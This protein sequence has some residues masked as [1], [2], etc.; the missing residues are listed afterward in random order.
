MV[1]DT[2][3]TTRSLEQ[4]KLDLGLETLALLEDPKTVEIM[5]NHK[6]QSST[7][8]RKYPTR[9]SYERLRGN[10]YDVKQYSKQIATEYNDE[11]KQNELDYV[12]KSKQYEAKSQLLTEEFNN[13]K[14]ASTEE[15]AYLQSKGVEATKGIYMKVVKNKHYTCIPFFNIEGKI[16][17][18]QYI[19]EYGNKRFETGG[20]KTGSFHVINGFD[21][22]NTST[23]GIIIAEGYATANTVNEA[24]NGKYSVIAAGD[25]GNLENVAKAIRSKYPNKDIIIAADNDHIRE[26]NV[27][28][29]HATQAAKNVGAMLVYPSFS[30]GVKASDFNDL[31]KISGIEVVRSSIR[32]QLSTQISNAKKLQQ[33]HNNSR[34]KN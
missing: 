7:I 8:T 10:Q 25:C 11:I 5:Q 32:E 28:L 12:N 15:S 33:E 20:K 18:K 24:T 22:L 6:K 31:K 23:A 17:T 14:Q 16:T 3:I 27:G 26:D 4:I 34:R 2:I 9:D 19:D 1:N 21:M 13:S 30:F 29:K